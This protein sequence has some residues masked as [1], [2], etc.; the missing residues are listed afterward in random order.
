MEFR[1]GGRR[2]TNDLTM[3]VARTGGT[4]AARNLRLSYSKFEQELGRKVL[5]TERISARL[6]KCNLGQ[7]RKSLRWTE[8]DMQKAHDIRSFVVRPICGF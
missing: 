6:S 8:H 4:T 5:E 2:Y 3:N 7:S 1:K